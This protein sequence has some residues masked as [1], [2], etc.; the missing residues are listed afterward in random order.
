MPHGWR[1]SDKTDSTPSLTEKLIT[2]A[3]WVQKEGHALIRRGG[4]NPNTTTD[5]MILVVGWCGQSDNT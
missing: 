3:G 2:K 4:E 1:I 5:M